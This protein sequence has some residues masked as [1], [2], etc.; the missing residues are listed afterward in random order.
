MEL[1]MATLYLTEQQTL[2]MVWL[3]ILQLKEIS[4]VLT[5]NTCTSLPWLPIQILY[6]HVRQDLEEHFLVLL[7]EIR[8]PMRLVQPEQ[9]VL[10][11]R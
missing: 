6:F 5:T 10:E 9:K 8:K 4:L 2:V 1:N 11:L 7:E 3:C